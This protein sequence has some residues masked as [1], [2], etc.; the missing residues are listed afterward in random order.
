[1]TPPAHIHRWSDSPLY[2]IVRHDARAACGG[3]LFHLIRRSMVG[4]TA[5]RLARSRDPA[6]LLF[7]EIRLE[8]LTDEAIEQG[9]GC[10]TWGPA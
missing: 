3:L 9:L 5:P 7:L 4:I 2:A 10:A 6:D 8:A 1:V